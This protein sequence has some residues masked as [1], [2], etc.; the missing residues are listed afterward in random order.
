M[1]GFCETAQKQIEP[2]QCVG[3]AD[4]G[5]AVLSEPA[6]V[7]VILTRA[8]TRVLPTG[9]GPIPLGTAMQSPEKKWI[10]DDSGPGVG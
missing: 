7:S 6:G 1:R 9:V 10:D 5:D 2:D 3:I 8:L 4:S